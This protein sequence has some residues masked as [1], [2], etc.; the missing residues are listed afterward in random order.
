MG[1]NFGKEN[2]GK[3]NPSPYSFFRHY[4]QLTDKTLANLKQITKFTKIFCYTVCH[5]IPKGQ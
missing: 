3:F 5:N 4:K 2:F 1:E